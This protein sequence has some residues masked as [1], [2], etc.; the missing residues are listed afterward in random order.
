MGSKD[1]QDT[2]CDERIEF[3]KGDSVIWQQR[4]GG[5]V[6]YRPGVV[7]GFKDRF[8]YDMFGNPTGETETVVVVA[9]LLDQGNRRQVESFI[10]GFIDEKR[11]LVAEA[12]PKLA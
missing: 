5:Q 10:D 6:R 7:R 2:V 11:K 4:L 1:T 12:P 3:A 9:V 8:V